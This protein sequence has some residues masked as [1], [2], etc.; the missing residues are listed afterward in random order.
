MLV[1][2]LKHMRNWPLFVIR[3]TSLWTDS[4]V[5]SLFLYICSELAYHES[6]ALLM[7]AINSTYLLFHVV[8]FPFNLNICDLS[9][10]CQNEENIQ[11]D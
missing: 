7:S 9:T 1:H 11:N 8:T 2:K 5:C 4:L 10:P 3:F 6:V